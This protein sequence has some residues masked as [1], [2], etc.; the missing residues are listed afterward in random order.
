MKTK[1]ASSISAEKYSFVK[2]I[3]CGTFL[4]ALVCTMILYI[5]AFCF[6]KMGSVPYSALSVVAV[7]SASIGA[8]CGGFVCIKIRKKQG[9][10][11]GSICGTVL[12]LLITLASFISTRESFSFYSIVKLFFMSLFGAIGGIIAVNKIKK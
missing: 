12:F 2:E 1:K 9:L 5:F 7:V 4:G 10:L 8:L 11:Y 6:V 3:L